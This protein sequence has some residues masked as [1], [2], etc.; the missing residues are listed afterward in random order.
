MLYSQSIVTEYNGVKRN[1]GVGVVS[2]KTIGANGGWGLAVQKPAHMLQAKGVRARTGAG[3]GASR[4]T[5]G[6]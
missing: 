1:D 6:I 4:G 2:A 3:K 5:A